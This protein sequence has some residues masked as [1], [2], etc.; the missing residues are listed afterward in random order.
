MIEIRYKKILFFQALFLFALAFLS[1]N[2]FAHNFSLMRFIIMWAIAIVLNLLIILRY[3][4][5]TKSL[6]SKINHDNIQGTQ[7]D[8]SWSEIEESITR[9]DVAFNKQKEEFE[10]ENLKYKRLLDSLQDPVSILNKNLDIIYINQAFTDLFHLDHQTLPVPLIQITRNLEFQEFLTNSITSNQTSKKSY[11][12]FNQL[13][14]PHKAYFD[15]KVFPVDSLDNFLCILHDVTERKMADQMREDFVSNFSHEVRTPLTILNGQMQTLKAKL[16]DSSE[17]ETNFA[18][19]FIKIDNNSRRLINLFNDLLR[20]TSVETKKEI[21][22]EDVQIEEMLT[23]LAHDLLHNYPKKKIHLDIMLEQ[24]KIWV[25]YNLF[26]QVLLNLIDNALKYIETEGTITIRSGHDDN[27]D[28]LT[29]KDSGVGIPEDQLHRIF[30]RFFRVD[31]SRSSEIEGTGLGLAIV[32]HIIQKHD[33]RIKATS[34]RG[35]GT[36]FTL[37]FPSH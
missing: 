20:L 35:A 16:Q 28:Y 10:L 24:K 5:P 13:Q 36:T 12:T 1:F 31:A 4:L 26:E 14:D 15:L 30:E 27:W 9:K 11:F 18:P 29:I 25:D 22:K 21:N 7:E 32:K 17:F 6:L 33:G 8:L 3:V 37:S 34:S 23:F 19:S 2:L